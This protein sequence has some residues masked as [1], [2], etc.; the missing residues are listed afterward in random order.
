[1]TQQSHTTII[2]DN[3]G[4]LRLDQALSQLFDQ[5]SRSQLQAWI[6]A[7]KVTVDGQAQR[8]RDKVYGGETVI[9]KYEETPQTDWQ[10]EAIPLTV[11]YE[12]DELIVIDKPVGMVV[13]PAAGH[14]SGTLCNALLY[15]HQGAELLPRAGIIHRLDKDTSGL[16]IVAK[17]MET[18]QR[19]VSMMQDRL[20]K[21]RYLAVVYGQMTAGGT[22]DE[23]VG[24]HPVDRKR[25]AVTPTGKPAVTHYR[26][27][28]RYEFH[29]VVDVELETGRTH[30]IRVHMAYLHYPIVGDQVYGGRLRIP[31]HCT[32]ELRSFLQGFKRQALHARHLEFQHP[33]SGQELI[34]E[35]PLP[36]D[37]SRLIELL[38]A[39]QQQYD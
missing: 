38:E 16:L 13:H 17:T 10:A 26:I 28:Q 2:P 31:R 39:E 23:P 35:S 11:V 34:F 14:A 19:L 5:F 24:R 15:H 7:G 30:Q 27:N 4:G 25:M 6:K 3:Y 9:L 33:V 37:I 1:M 18:Y 8:A 36:D 32:S 29:T 20:I 22:I 12:D 21:R